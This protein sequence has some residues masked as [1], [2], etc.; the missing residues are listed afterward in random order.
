MKLEELKEKIEDIEV[1]WDYETTY[2]NLYNAC[3]DY[4]NETQDSDVDL[5]TPFEDIFNYEVIEDI[6][7]QELERGGLVRLY[8]FMGN[9]N[10][11]TQDII[12]INAYGNCEEIHKDDLECIKERIIENIDLILNREKDISF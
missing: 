1:S 10:F 6:A 7:K 12:R 11:D 2:N 3:I 4:Q 9:V 5:E 8:Y